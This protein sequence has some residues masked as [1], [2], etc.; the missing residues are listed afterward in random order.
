MRHWNTMVPILQRSALASYCSDM[1]TSGAYNDNTIWLEIIIIIIDKGTFW[2]KNSQ[3][4]VRK[5]STNG[6]PFKSLISYDNN[7]IYIHII[8]EQY[9]LCVL[10][11]HSH[12]LTIYIGD[13]HSVAAI[14]PSFKNL[15]NPKSAANEMILIYISTRQI[16][17][18]K[19]TTGFSFKLCISS[20]YSTENLNITDTYNWVNNFRKTKHFNEIW[21]YSLNRNIF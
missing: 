5:L 9:L 12:V 4:I 7:I 8:N 15:A 16:I 17:F 1:I 14:T 18:I 21:I 6:P 2:R 19:S 20:V 10:V 11:L 3:I 13:P